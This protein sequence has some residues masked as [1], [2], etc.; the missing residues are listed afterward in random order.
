MLSKE[1][2][3]GDQK[4]SIKKEWLQRA[5]QRAKEEEFYDQ[6]RVYPEI[7]AQLHGY[8]RSDR[9]DSTRRKFLLVDVGSGTVDST[10]VNVTLQ[11]S[12]PRYNFLQTSVDLLGTI[13]LHRERLKF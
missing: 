9:W 11:D 7:A 12:E 4:H 8:I 3:W 13:I 5:T 6:V 2:Q 10:V 1:P